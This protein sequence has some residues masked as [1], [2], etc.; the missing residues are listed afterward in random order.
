MSSKSRVVRAALAAALVVFA[1]SPA[2]AL[3]WT[4]EAIVRKGSADPAGSEFA[5]KFGKKRH[6][7][8]AINSS[9]DVVFFATPKGGPRRLWRLC[10]GAGKARHR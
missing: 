1:S 3:T 10:Q 6:G 2:D 8:P 9:G 4:C 5:G 7:G